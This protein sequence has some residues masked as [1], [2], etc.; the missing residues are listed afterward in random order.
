MRKKDTVRWRSNSCHD[1]NEDGRKVSPPRAWCLGLRETN[2][3]TVS[4]WVSNNNREGDLRGAVIY[5]PTKTRENE[6]NVSG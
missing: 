5:I 4:E 6:S 2:E 1:P 3:T